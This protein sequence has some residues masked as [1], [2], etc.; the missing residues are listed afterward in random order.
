MAAGSPSAALEPL[1]GENCVS[2]VMM[3]EQSESVAQAP[4][5]WRL[6]N[7]SRRLFID[8]RHSQTG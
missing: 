7:E 2:V 1:H 8:R 6:V 5:D 4:V 3:R